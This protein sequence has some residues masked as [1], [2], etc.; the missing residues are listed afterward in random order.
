VLFRSA[1]S[2]TPRP[3]PIRR[4]PIRRLL[5]DTPSRLEARIRPRIRS[6]RSPWA[7]EPPGDAIG[8]RSAAGGREVLPVL[9]RPPATAPPPADAGEAL[10][11]RATVEDHARLVP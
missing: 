10:D 1:R 9:E 11:H 7:P 5:V 4:C 6:G 2:T 8:G 3:A